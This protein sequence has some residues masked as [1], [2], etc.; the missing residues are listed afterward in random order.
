MKMRHVHGEVLLAAADS[1]LVG[2]E[3]REGRLHIRVDPNFYGEIKV[4]EEMFI[5]SLG[6]CTIANLVGKRVVGIA[7]EKE[8]VD[9]ENVI[10]ID[11]IPHAQYAKME[12]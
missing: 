7:I 3:F 8:F 11:G 2:K 4:S 10:Y 6:M 9:P 12:E 5:T 1:E